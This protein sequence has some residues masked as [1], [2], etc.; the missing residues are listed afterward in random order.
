MKKVK[1]VKLEEITIPE[2]RCYNIKKMGKIKKDLESLLKKGGKDFSIKA[3]IEEV[4]Q[5][6]IL[7]YDLIEYAISILD[8]EIVIGNMIVNTFIAYK[9]DSD[10]D[11]LLGA[12]KSL[13]RWTLQFSGLAKKFF[14]KLFLGKTNSNPACK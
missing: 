12:V 8:N 6:E 7:D 2:F 1:R 11:E 9:K 4:G 13:A 5:Y 10:I 3:Y 14:K